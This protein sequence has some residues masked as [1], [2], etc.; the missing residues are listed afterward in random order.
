MEA[1]LLDGSSPVT[2][3]APDTETAPTMTSAPPGGQPASVCTVPGGC[4]TYIVQA[5]DYPVGV[6]E[7]FTA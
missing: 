4:G 3:L 5:G 2:P 7:R 1:T 6:A